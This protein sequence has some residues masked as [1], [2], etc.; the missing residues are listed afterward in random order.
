MATKKTETIEI[1]IELA[2]LLVTEP[3][4]LKNPED[5]EYVQRLAKASLRVLIAAQ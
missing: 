3:K 5:H 2:R 4:D 1:P